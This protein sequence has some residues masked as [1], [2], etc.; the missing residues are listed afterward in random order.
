[1]GFFIVLALLGILVVLY[2]GFELVVEH[3][4]AIVIALEKK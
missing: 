3:L 2:I 4:K 1:M